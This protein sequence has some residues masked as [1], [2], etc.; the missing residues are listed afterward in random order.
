MPDNRRRGTGLRF[1]IAAPCRVVSLS[2]V[3]EFAFGAAVIVT[4]E[5]I[6]F[7]LRSEQ[8]GTFRSAFSRV[9]GLAWWMLCVLFCA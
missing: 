7:L 1:L 8:V 2:H 3:D 6:V 5:R 9:V 4:R